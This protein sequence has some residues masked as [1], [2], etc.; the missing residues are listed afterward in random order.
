MTYELKIGDKITRDNW[1]ENTYMVVEWFN[2]T[3]V[4]GY[5]SGAN[6]VRH[7]VT[8][9]YKS[10]SSLP[11][12]L[13]APPVVK[14]QWLVTTET[15]PP[16]PGED[17]SVIVYNNNTFTKFAVEPCGVVGF[18]RNIITKIEEFRP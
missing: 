12:R 16:K 6:H 10:G 11:F 5:I 4:C 18:V 14:K 17:A 2:D 8:Y 13:W 9:D 3:L 7:G 1:D 15:R